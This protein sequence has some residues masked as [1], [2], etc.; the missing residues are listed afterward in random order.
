[1][2]SGTVLVDAET[3]HVIMTIVFVRFSSRTSEVQHA[4]F[5][6]LLAVYKLPNPS[7][8]GITPDGQSQ[9]PIDSD[10]RNVSTRVRRPPQQT[11]PTFRTLLTTSSITVQQGCKVGKR[12]S[13]APRTC[14]PLSLAFGVLAGSANSSL[15]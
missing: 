7:R 12:V 2:I 8:T 4:L 3:F 11:T 9:I 15:Q 14:A 10:S 6:C 1:M 13:I 5:S